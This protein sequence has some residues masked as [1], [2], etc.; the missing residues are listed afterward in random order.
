MRPV[1]G[2][3]SLHAASRRIAVCV[4]RP[5]A[6]RALPNIL[7]PG[8]LWCRPNSRR[9]CRLH[10]SCLPAAAC[11]AK[12]CKSSGPAVFC[13]SSTSV[14]RSRWPGCMS[15]SAPPAVRPACRSIPALS[16]AR[17]ASVRTLAQ[18]FCAVER[19]LT[20]RRNIIWSSLPPAPTLHGTL[21]HCWQSMSLHRTAP[22]ATV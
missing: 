17:P 4:R 14:R 21:K 19:S 22:G 11:R 12:F 3:R 6:L 7:M 10:S 2:R 16:A 5:M 1:R 9:R 8:A 13:T 18:L 15:C 20:R